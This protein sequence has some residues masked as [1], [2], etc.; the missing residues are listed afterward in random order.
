MVLF[1]FHSLIFVLLAAFVPPVLLLGFR[2]QALRLAGEI[3]LSVGFLGTMIGM[4]QMLQQMGGP[5]ALGPA[6]SVALL[7]SIYA[8][9]IKLMLDLLHDPQEEIAKVSKSRGIAASAAF[10]TVVLAAMLLGSGLRVFVSLTAVVLVVLG[11]LLIAGFSKSFGIAPLQGLVRQLPTMAV[12]VLLAS[13]VCILSNLHELNQIGPI[14]AWGFLG[15]FYAILGN[16]SL[17][18]Y[19]PNQLKAPAA[20]GQWGVFGTLNAGALV[21]MA[22]VVLSMKMGG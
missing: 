17:R 16:V 21:V 13:C 6:I 12:L 10:L 2:K 7:T 1:D 19:S 3:V 5:S 11:G 9:G 22:L 15:A 18:L 4:V 14:I 8:I 20:T